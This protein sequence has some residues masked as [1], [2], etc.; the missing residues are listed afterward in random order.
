MA[1]ALKITR[2]QPLDNPPTLL[3]TAASPAE[4]PELPE[5]TGVFRGR[6]LTRK[7]RRLASRITLVDNLIGG[8]IVRGRVSEILGAAGSG[9]TSLAAAFVANITRH[10]EVAAWIDAVDNFDPESMVAA[11]IDLARMLWVS[12]RYPNNRS[13]R[14]RSPA[15]FD[16]EGGISMN[17]DRRRVL[18]AT[19]LKAA[20]WILAAGGFGLVVIDFGIG[21]RALPQST[22]LRLAHAAERSGT[23]VLA[24]APHRMCGTFAAVSLTLRRNRACFSR[25]RPGA[26]ALFDGLKVEAN[27]ARNKLGG[28]GR[29]AN[30]SLLCAPCTDE[31]QAPPAP[32]EGQHPRPLQRIQMK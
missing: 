4:V 22:A 2:L 10:G 7:D 5:F 21:A 6:E 13:H 11:G 18:P 28:S 31:L 8:G 9:K 25:T 30:F 32:L 12:C 27:V 17:S 19:G 24:L 15:A 20:E 23:A 26:P 16:D 1:A 29:S 14:S 3:R